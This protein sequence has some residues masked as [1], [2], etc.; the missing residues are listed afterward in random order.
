MEKM[1]REEQVD[2]LYQLLGDEVGDIVI[3]WLSE[4]NFFTAPAAKGH[5]GAYCGGLF[6]HSVEVASQ[7][8]RLSERNDL[9]WERRNSPGIVGVL[10]D[11]CKLDDYVWIY[12]DELDDDGNLVIDTIKWNENQIMKGHGAKSVKMLEDVID[13]TEEEKTCIRY[14]MGA[15]VDKSEWSAYSNSVQHNVNLLYT[16]TADMIASQVIGV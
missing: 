15:F 12:K 14:H 16:H 5:H 3:P 13:L 7:L 10:H 1:S 8:Y 11:V 4:N 9:V 2:I 6:V